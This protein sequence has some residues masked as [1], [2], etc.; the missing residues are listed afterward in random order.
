MSAEKFFIASRQTFLLLSSFLLLFSAALHGNTYYVDAQNGSDNYDGRSAS[1]QGGNAGPWKTINKINTTSFNP[2]DS[3]LFKRGAT[4]SDG[5]LYP[6]NGGS[7]GGTITIQETILSQP[8]QFQLVDPNNHSCIYFGAYGLGVKPKIECNGDEGLIIRH[9]YIIIEDLH[10]NNGG[11]NMLSFSRVGGNYWNVVRNV[12]VTN[13]SGSGVRFEE[14]GGNCWLDGLHVYNYTRNGIYLEG[15]AANPLKEVLV[16]NCRIE[17]SFPVINKFDGL[18]CHRDSEG[19]NIDGNIII[20]R[21]TII[22]AGE[23][24]IDV[25][26]G[27]HILL[28]GNTLEH[29]NSSGIFVGKPERVH[30]VEIRENVLNS[31]SRKKGVGDLTISAPNVRV[32]NN[33]ILGTGHHCLLLKTTANVQVWNN[34]IAPSNR[35]GNFI[36]LKDSTRQIEFRNNIFDFSTTTQTISGLFEAASFDYNCYFGRSR[37]QEIYAG[38]SFYDLQ[39]QDASYEPNGFW[40]DPLFLHPNRTFPEHLKLSENSPCIDSGTNLPVNTDFGGNTRP[41]GGGIDI[42]VFESEFPAPTSSTAMTIAKVRNTNDDA[43]ENDK[44]GVNLNSTDLEMANIG[45][46]LQIVGIRFNNLN[47]QPGALITDA[48]IQFMADEA[49]SGPSSLTITGEAADNPS[50]FTTNKYNVSSRSRTATSVNWSPSDWPAIR[51]IEVNQQTPDLSSIVQEIINRP[52]WTNDNSMVFLI[53][54]TGVR[55]AESYDGSTQGAPT[56]FIE[57]AIGCPDAGTACNDDNPATYNEVEDGNCNCIGTPC[58]AA[59]MACDDGNPD[60]ENDAEDGFCNCIGTPTSDTTLTAQIE[61][62]EYVKSLNLP[63]TTGTNKTSQMELFPNPASYQLNIRTR[64]AETADENVQ[65]IIHDLSGKIILSQSISVLPGEWMAH[66]LNIGQLSTGVYFVRL[67]IGADILTKRF[68]K[69][70]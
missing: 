9:N 25:T 39:Y 63:L 68:V 11:N 67:N 41:Q 65:M 56:L 51:E 8:L 52:G 18:S 1:V 15:S 64:F 31:N 62:P 3:I 10:F 32:M 7:P 14:G 44:G 6:K 48:Y 42:G 57:Y 29:N 36:W 69:I 70:E 50:E 22:G 17:K 37:S 46:K 66:L 26:S 5:P 16:E 30:T 47:L 19:N 59:G 35:T 40:A 55:T 43:E 53:E 60:T 34:V 38:N 45:T 54:G 13:S 61:K 12:A 2:G 49:T 24:G 4:W 21:N 58:P 20:R 28:V 27:T 33:I 23:D